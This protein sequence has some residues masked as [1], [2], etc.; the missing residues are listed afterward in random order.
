MTVVFEFLD[1]EPIENVITCL[2]YKADKVVYLG[3]Q[4]TINEVSEST[5]NFLKSVCGVG[6]VSFMSLSHEK[7]DST[8]K[9]ISSVIEKEKSEHNDLF[10]DITGGEE[11][12]LVAFGMLADKHKVP[13]HFYDVAKGRLIVLS[14]DAPY[15]IRDR[16]EEREIKLNL[17]QYIR[18]SGGIINENY[19]KEYKKQLSGSELEE[20]KKIW[21]VAGK[22][23]ENWNVF[24]NIMKRLVGDSAEMLVEGKYREILKLF[25]DTAYKKLQTPNALNA[26]LDDLSS[27][28]ILSDVIHSDGKYRFRFKNSHVRES[29]LDGGSILELFVFS[30]EYDHADDCRVGVHLDWDGVIEGGSGRDVYNEVDVLTIKDNIPTFISCKSGQMTGP[31]PL[32]ALYELN[33]VAERFG[34]KYAQKKLAISQP[35][36]DVNYKRAKEMGIEIIDIFGNKTMLDVED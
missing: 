11:L 34:G 30:Q 23:A 29:L 32:Q 20:V 25:E 10:F 22:H 21:Q 33:S 19:D 31:K 14:N 8:K 35:I 26:I 36:S 5:E 27:V 28:G 3:Y 2:H 7:L 24:S 4:E 9:N 18:M 12:S 1:V 13:I 6:S 17:D 15:T 16:G